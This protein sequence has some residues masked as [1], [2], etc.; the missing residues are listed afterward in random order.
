MSGRIL[1]A[2]DD[3]DLHVI[4]TD[5]LKSRGYEILAVTDGQAAIDVLATDKFNL[6]ILDLSMPK[7]D[8]WT[9]LRQLRARPETQS[10]PVLVLTAHAFA[11]DEEHARQA[12][13]NEF[14]AKPFDP[15]IL[16]QRVQHLLGEPATGLKS[17]TSD[18]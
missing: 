5:F 16:L 18:L 12:G 14:L 17:E 8:G 7:V 4:L 1:I 10:L 15:Y 3:G 9:V 2:E 13:C 11:R 6:L